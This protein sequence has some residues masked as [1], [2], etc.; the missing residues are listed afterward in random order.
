MFISD[1][2]PI[3]PDREMEFRLMRIVIGMRGSLVMIKGMDSAFK[4]L[5][6][7]IS[8]QGSGK[9]TSNMEKVH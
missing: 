3:M 2:G 4:I 7:A 8:T 1:N 5:S 9:I 6:M